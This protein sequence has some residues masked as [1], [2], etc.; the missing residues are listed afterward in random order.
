MA[1]IAWPIHVAWPADVQH[2]Q[3][4]SEAV[5][6]WMLANHAVTSE[7]AGREALR[8]LTEANEKRWKRTLAWRTAMAG[9]IVTLLPGLT[10]T[11]FLA[12]L[13]LGA[14]AAMT[15][16]L[17]RWGRLSVAR[18]DRWHQYTAEVEA[19]GTAAF[20]LTAGI[21]VGG[22]GLTV[23]APAVLIPLSIGKATALCCIAAAVTF[24]VGGGTHIVR[25]V[26]DKVQALPRPRNSKETQSLPSKEGKVDI[27]EYNRGR[28][29]GNLER[30]LMIALIGAGSYEGL[31][32]LVAAKGLIRASEFDNR[33]LAEYFIV[34]NLC[35]VAVAMAIGLPLRA[36]VSVLWL[37]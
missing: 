37:L 35:S 36:A 14:A 21:I 34:G 28:T 18:S 15:T 7:W 6:V 29:I 25:G 22:A 27:T 26:L 11:H 23:N 5:L 16:G 8:D 4:W 2:Y 12:R 17:L 31:G 1:L 24:V 33:D 13:T 9:S 10:W 30:V 20:L 3:L 19:I 32:L